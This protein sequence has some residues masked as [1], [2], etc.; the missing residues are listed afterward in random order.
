M[1]IDIIVVLL[2]LFFIGLSIYVLWQIYHACKN[3]NEKSN[4][5]IMTSNDILIL[6]KDDNNRIHTKVIKKEDI[7]ID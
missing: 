5:V 2:A 3:E 6:V 1:L 4:V 7:I